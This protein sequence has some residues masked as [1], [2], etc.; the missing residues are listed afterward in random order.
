MSSF[1]SG[2]GEDDSICIKSEWLSNSRYY[3]VHFENIV[4]YGDILYSVIASHHQQKCKWPYN[5]W[6]TL[7]YHIKTVVTVSQTERDVQRNPGFPGMPWVPCCWWCRVL[8]WN[9]LGMHIAVKSGG[10]GEARTRGTEQGH[11]DKLSNPF[12]PQDSMGRRD[13]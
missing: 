4:A 8:T 12:C 3:H 6:L 13:H 9:T 5:V 2:C 11:E 10:G 7:Q 1:S